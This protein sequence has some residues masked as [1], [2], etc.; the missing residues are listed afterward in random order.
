MGDKMHKVTLEELSGV[1]LA[2]GTE[3]AKGSV[4]QILGSRGTAVYDGEGHW[5]LQNDDLGE[6]LDV[7]QAAAEAQ[8]Q[9][10]RR[11][12]EFLELIAAALTT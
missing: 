7:I 1:G 8:L 4:V 2:H 11:T 10:Q 3:P 6:K 12:N 5:I 9:E